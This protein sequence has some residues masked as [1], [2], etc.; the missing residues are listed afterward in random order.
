MSTLKD[1]INNI[2]ETIADF[3]ELEVV[4]LSGE[5]K[6]EYLA[7]GIQEPVVRTKTIEQLKTEAGD[8]RK[9]LAEA[10]KKVAAATEN[11]TNAAKACAIAVATAD[12]TQAALAAKKALADA[13]G[14]VRSAQLDAENAAAAATVASRAW[15]AAQDDQSKSAIK[16]SSLIADATTNTSGT[17]RV[18]AIT[19]IKI[20]GDS[21][22]FVSDK[23]TDRDLAA[24]DA[25]VAASQETRRAILEFFRTSITSIVKAT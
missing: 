24:H 5:L 12:D 8:A 9:K 10:A 18:S 23:A 22:K 2:G 20:D 17:V 19:V 16:W 11:A 21:Y 6:Q 15:A 4:T 14:A 25:A 13:K 7:G 1:A 3:S